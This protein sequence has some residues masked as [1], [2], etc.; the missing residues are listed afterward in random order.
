LGLG[1]GA[2]RF[3]AL[4]ALRGGGLG[5]LRATFLQVASQFG[6]E[7]RC[8]TGVLDGGIRVGDHVLGDLAA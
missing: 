1:L 4:S 6:L 8:K 2:D 3:F 7:L 5:D